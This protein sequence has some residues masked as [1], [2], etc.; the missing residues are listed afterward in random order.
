MTAIR[1]TITPSHPQAHLFA[2]SCS[3]AAPDPAGQRFSLPAWIPGSYMIREFARN[4]VR[5]RAESQGKPVSLTKL[6]KHTWQAAPCAAL[7]T[8]TYEV[9]AW[10]MSVRCAHLD[11]NQG[12]FNGTQVFVAVAGA[13]QGEHLVEL[14]PPPVGIGRDWRVATTLPEAIGKNGAAKRGGFG[15]YRAVNYDELIDHPVALGQFSSASFDS[16]GVPHEIVI[17][18][19]IRADMQLLAADLARICATHIS[20]FGAPPPFERYLFLVH[21]IGEGHGG[22]EHRSSTA[23]ICARDDLPAINHKKMSDGYASFLSLCSHEY[24]HSWNVKRIKPAAFIPYD[25]SRENHTALLWAFEGFTSY[26]DD[27]GLRR[28]G[29]ISAENYLAR[30]AKTISNVEKGSGRHK[31]TLAESSFDAWIKYYR[32]DENSPNAIVSYYDK[33]ALV[34]LCLDLTLRIKTEGRVSLD[35][36][37]RE[38]WRAYGKIGRGVPDDGIRQ[39]AESLSGLDLRRFFADAVDGTGDLPL[40]R[41]LKAA[42]IVLTLDATSEKPSLG[43][44]TT[45]ESKA[46]RISQVFDGGAAQQAGLSAGD[47]L[48]AIDGLRIDAGNLD[49]LLARYQA[50]DTVAIHAFRRDELMTCSALLQPPARNVCKLSSALRPTPAQLA[51]RKHWLGVE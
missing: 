26:Y 48:V 28:A 18:G 11:T 3:I 36:V 39:V 32:Q 2:V 50:G 23:L 24:F 41:L 21:A 30:L 45:A 9:Y 29:V 33:G 15:W 37:M 46:L 17:A 14:R 20:L 35:D 42:G 31:Q 51:F 40:Q 7:L 8:L 6:D 10:D 25:L 22:L 27:L 4:I 47:T 19:R 12:F 38:L 16:C 1:Y 44:K 13:E 43:I 49:T 34:A 5:I